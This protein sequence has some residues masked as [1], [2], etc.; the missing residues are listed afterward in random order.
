MSLVYLGKLFT[1]ML[2]PCHYSCGKPKT[3]PR[4]SN[5]DKATQLDDKIRLVNPSPDPKMN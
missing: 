2:N 1:S 5:V 3:E 4:C